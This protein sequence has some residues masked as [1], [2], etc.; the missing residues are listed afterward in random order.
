MKKVE[1][2]TLIITSVL[3]AIT[4]VI[5][6]VLDWSVD[7][8]DFLKVQNYQFYFQ[9]WI[10]AAG[11]LFT[12]I[13]AITTFIIYKKSGLNSL[14][15]ISISF[16]LT[17][18]AY[19]LIGYHSSYCKVCSDLSMCSSSHNYPNYFAVI[20]LVITAITA[21]LVNLK[22]NITHLKLFSIGII[23]ASFLLLLT[24]FISIQFMETPDIILYE[25]ININLQGFVFIFPLILIIL[26]FIY[27]KS[28]YKTTNIITL[29]FILMFISFVPQAYH[30]F[31]C[32]ECHT[33][34]CSEFYVFSGLIMFIAMGLLIYSIS[35][36]M[37]E[38]N[39]N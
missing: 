14:K 29:V 19:L 20:A 23:S 13:M 21:L 18:F 35:L 34:E 22:N 7:G 15:F 10:S 4:A 5:F 30:I 16:F 6:T 25:I 8:F 24:L 27:F 31:M 37:L 12:L 32:T 1:K 39:N 9:S 2:K 26:S 11:I 17:S 28:I 38:K 33:M 3:L 36:Q